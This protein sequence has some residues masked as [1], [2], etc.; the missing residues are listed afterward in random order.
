MKKLLSIMLALVM[1]ISAAGSMVLAEEA[2]PTTSQDIYGWGR[3]DSLNTDETLYDTVNVIEDAAYGH[4]VEVIKQSPSKSNSMLGIIQ[5]VSPSKLISGHTYVLEYKYKM[6][7]PSAGYWLQNGFEWKDASGTYKSSFSQPYSGNDGDKGWKS[8]S[9]KITY[10]EADFQYGFSVRFFSANGEARFCYADI[11]LYDE[12]DALKTNILLNGDFS[13]TI[14]Q[15]EPNYLYGW[16]ERHSGKDCTTDTK[17]TLDTISL[18]GDSSFGTV[19]LINK[20]TASSSN[21]WKGVSQTIDASALTAGKTY[22]CEADYRGN[23]EGSY[24][25]L[26]FG[27]TNFD[28][29]KTNY[30]GW[31]HWKQEQE[32]SSGDLKV[33]FWCINAATEFYIANVTVYDKDDPSKTNLLV[34]GDFTHVDGDNSDGLYSWTVAN[35]AYEE[36]KVYIVDNVDYGRAALINKK[37]GRASDSMLGIKA[38]VSADKLVKGNTYVVEY[39]TK[40]DPTA[41]NY[42]KTGWSTFTKPEYSDPFGLYEREWKLRTNEKTYSGTGDMGLFFGLTGAAGRIWIA[43]VKVYDKADETKTNLLTNGNFAGL[44]D[45]SVEFTYAD[46]YCTANII[47]KNKAY[48]ALIALPIYDDNNN[49]VYVESYP[50]EISA[51]NQVQTF[52]EFVNILGDGYHSKAFLWDADT[53]EP[54][55]GPLDIE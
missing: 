37:S 14:E 3:T 44:P 12:A 48:T 54:L 19:L 40:L 33:G 17:E 47:S 10:T 46:G 21:S 7:K 52:R 2:V 8:T 38:S 28:R 16:T 1:S 49:L 34:N 35:T 23:A 42:G 15:H 20:K 30:V 45:S 27:S 39:Y 24:T 29:Y 53:L 9:K 55:A 11:N 13:E 25:R 22:V 41:D 36:D 4:A 51:G 43:D 18:C 31:H 26:T 32:Y 50:H 5:K 6:D